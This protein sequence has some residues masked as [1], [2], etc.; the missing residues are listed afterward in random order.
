M[1][2]ET[3]DEMEDFEA[4]GDQFDF[5]NTD[6]EEMEEETGGPKIK[7]RTHRK[8][9]P[10]IIAEKTHVEIEYEQENEPLENL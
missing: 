7:K 5:M 2:G 9:D 10:L 8:N 1:E 4:F 3:E 6:D